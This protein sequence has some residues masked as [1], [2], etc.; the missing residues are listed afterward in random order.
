MK[1]KEECYNC[2]KGL[3]E[4]T[5]S[6]SRGDASVNTSAVALLDLLWA[7]G[8]TPPAMANRLLGHI[9]EATG[10]YDPYGPRKRME[11]EK[12][13]EAATRLEGLFGP[14]LEGALMFSA[15]G[16]STDFFVDDGFEPERFNFHGQVDKIGEE[17]YTKGRE[18]LMLGDNV[19]DFLFDLRLIRFLEGLGKRVFYA[20]RAYPVQNDLSLKEVAAF[21]LV[22][23]WG[24]IVS[25]G[26]GE[27]GIRKEEM[28]GAIR[29]LWEGDGPVIAKGMGNY[30]TMSG[31][32]DG[33]PVI[34]IMKVKCRAVAE[35]V[36]HGMGSYIAI[37]GGETN[38]R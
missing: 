2:L 24:S 25:T 3:I 7:R 21:G 10:S 12:A 5:V 6:L 30:E 27:V 18:V 8:D 35:H 13:R 26:T 37:L 31:F 19:G 9:K 16:N 17:I 22:G 1:V 32:D 4:G 15:L 29:D 14:G 36:G 38:G 33:R 20:V 11:F 23:M 34:H 28:N